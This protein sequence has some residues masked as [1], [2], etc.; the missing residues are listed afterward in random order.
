[1]KIDK[2]IIFCVYKGAYRKIK[3]QSFHLKFFMVWALPIVSIYTKFQLNRFTCSRDIVVI[4]NGFISIL[5]F[6]AFRK[7]WI[8]IFW[9]NI[10]YCGLRQTSSKTF[11]YHIYQYE[12]YLRYSIE[13]YPMHSVVAYVQWLFK[14]SSFLLE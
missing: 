1:M 4:L 7:N 5:N 13:Q 11:V 2:M 14:Y 10:F 8:K 6:S 9:F 12:R 3:I